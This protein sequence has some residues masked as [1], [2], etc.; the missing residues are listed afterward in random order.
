M[1]KFSSYGPID[2]E[3][4]YYVPRQEL[5][6][7]AIQQLLG[8]NPNK[9]GHYIT[10]WAPR[11]RGKTW[12]MREVFLRLQH[13][14][15]FDV[16]VL[17]LQHLNMTTD[18]NRVAQLIARDLMEKLVLEKQ[19]TINSLDDFYQLFKQSTLKKPLIL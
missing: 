8:D 15:P 9:G 10:V 16:V 7:G 13:K 17:S 1:R 11:Q 18:V 14:E 4:H 3:L 19:P 6:D 12:I 5:I 2:Q